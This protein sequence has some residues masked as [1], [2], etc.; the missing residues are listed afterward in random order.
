MNNIRLVVSD[1]DFTLLNSERKLSAVTQKML[2]KIVDAGVQVVPCSARPITLMPSWFT[3]NPAVKYLVCSN[4]AVIMDNQTRK[5]LKRFTLS[6]KTV[7]AIIHTAKATPYWTVA[8]DG[9]FHSHVDI[10]RDF[11]RIGK[12]EGF[13]EDLLKTRIIEDNEDFISRC[14]EGSIEK[15]HLITAALSEQQRDQ[16]I[17]QLSCIEGI[18]VSSSH[19]SNLEIFHPQAGKGEAVR[20]LMKTMDLTKEQV[21]ACGDNENDLPML[22]EAGIRIAVA[23]ATPQ[24]KACADLLAEDCDHDGVVRSLCDL[25]K[26]EKED[27]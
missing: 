12:T 18:K 6:N 10:I 19:K 3:E 8:V 13:V 14:P 15:V 20:W 21:V 7:L 1:L 26:I 16:L 5:P 11:D 17:R 4:G 25:L 9:K 2:Q 24:V 22:K 23:N 27:L